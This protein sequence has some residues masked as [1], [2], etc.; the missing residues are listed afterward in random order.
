M[1]TGLRDAVR[2]SIIEPFQSLFGAFTEPM[3]VRQRPYA[4]RQGR[5]ERN[6]AAAADHFERGMRGSGRL[7]HDGGRP[8]GSILNDWREHLITFRIRSRSSFLHPLRTYLNLHAPRNSRRG[9]LAVSADGVAIG[10]VM[11]A[12][13]CALARMKP[14]NPPESGSGILA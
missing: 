14:S 13:L 7:G 1:P 9:G 4:H 11:A 8:L 3:G 2:F 12:S 10:T 6:A 5:E